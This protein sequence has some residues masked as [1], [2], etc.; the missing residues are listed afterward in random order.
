MTPNDEGIGIASFADFVPP[1][2]LV[3]PALPVLPPRPVAANDGASG[4]RLSSTDFSSTE[5]PAVP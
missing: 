3:L 5:P 2:L 1:A 4:R